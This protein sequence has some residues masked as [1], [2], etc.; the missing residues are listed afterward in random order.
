M[1]W[2]ASTGPQDLGSKEI[3][4]S[5]CPAAS[6]STLNRNGVVDDFAVLRMICE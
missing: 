6:A 4:F 5:R 1:G 3:G 2:K